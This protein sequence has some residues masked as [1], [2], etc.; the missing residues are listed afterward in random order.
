M[1]RAV[2]SMFALM[3]VLPHTFTDAAE[4]KAIQAERREAQKQRQ[5]KKTER[6]KGNNEAL[7]QFR[8][9]VTELKREYRDKAR[10]LDTEYRLQRTELRA[11][12]QMKTVEVEAELQQSITQL[13]LTPPN[14]NN[15]QSIEKLKEDMKVYQDKMYEVRKAGALQEHEE[16]IANELRKHELMNQR[17]AKALDEARQLGLLDKHDP[18]VAT[19]IGGSLTPSEERWNER[20]KVEVERMYQGNQRQLTEFIVGGKLREWEIGNKREDFELEWRKRAELHEISSEQQYFNSL[21]F[22]G[23]G[24]QSPQEIAQQLTEISKK[25]QM[26]NI[27]YN[28]LNQQNQT[29]RRVARRQIMGR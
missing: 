18:I 5:Q 24:A 6:N 1:R 29:K 16:L 2:I 11:E 9:F 23:G 19:A 22:S 20:E 8:A 13:L 10:D 25:N 14:G 27:K 21:V 3:T 28:K 4:D 17:D 26:I 7:R 12:R 15:Q